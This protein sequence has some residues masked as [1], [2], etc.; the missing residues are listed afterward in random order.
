[1]S[2][3]ATLRLSILDQSPVPSG[4]TPAQALRNSIALA[5]HVESLGYRRFWMSEHHAMEMLA[6]TAPEIMLARIGAETS[7]IR[8]G[9]RLT[10]PLRSR[11]IETDRFLRP[12]SHACS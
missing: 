7:H 12:G 10:S 3:P 1:M 5:Q 2:T 6:C 8:I 11:R 9:K 4:S